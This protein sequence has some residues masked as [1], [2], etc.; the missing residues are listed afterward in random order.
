MKR[1]T[2][3]FA[4]LVLGICCEAQRHPLFPKSMVVAQFA[5]STGLVS[6][7]FSKVTARDNIELGLLYGYLPKAY[8]GN[9]H[10]LSLKFAWNPWQFR[11]FNRLSIE[12]VQ[13]GA[14]ICQNFNKDLEFAWGNNY[15]KNYYWWPRATRFHPTL[16][17]Q[18]A[19]VFDS[20]RVDRLA[21]YFEA[22]TNDLYIASWYPNRKALSLYD[23]IFFGMGLKLYFK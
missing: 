1:L 22:N 10:S 3:I 2:N 5:G 9:N 16:S 19:Y 6:A 8:G 14:F 4:L 23:I 7:G 15:P 11:A 17:T 21:Y 20:K 18:L 12:P 13:L